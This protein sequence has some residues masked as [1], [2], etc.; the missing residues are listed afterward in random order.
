[1]EN[2]QDKI[3][4]NVKPEL[5]E[6]PPIVV[7]MGHV[8]HGK[9][10]LLDAIRKTNVVGKEAGGITQGIGAYEVTRINADYTQTDADKDA[11][12]RGENIGVDQR[13]NQRASARKITFIDTP[14]H[15]AFFAMR[16]HGAKLADVALLVVAADDGVRPQT[17]EAIKHIQEAKIPF[18]VVI[19]KTDKPG[20]VTDRV[21]KELADRDVLIEEWGGK[22]P[23]AAVSAKTGEGIDELLDLILLVAELEEL[24]YDPA[25]PGE[26]YVVEANLDGRR[27]VTATIIITSGCFKECDMLVCGSVFGPIKIMEDDRGQALEEACPSK[28]VRVV[29][30]SELPLV[31]EK[32]EIVPK[33]QD[34]SAIISE[35]EHEHRAFLE[36]L[37]IEPAGQ[38]KILLLV[39]KSSAQGSLAAVL[40]VLKEIKSDR[41]GLKLLKH[42][43]GD[44]NQSDV[45]QAETSAARVVGFRV[46]VNKEAA[47]YADQR[48]VVVKTFDV[49][50]EFVEA[51]KKMMAELLEPEIVK[52]ELGRLEILAVFKAGKPRAIV[53]G[54]IFSGKLRQGLKVEIFRNDVSLGLG[55]IVEL[56]RNK[57]P[58][59]EVGAGNEA[60]I[61]LES[62]AAAAV[63]DVLAGFEEERKYPEL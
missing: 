63:G 7:V 1:M 16:A 39:V 50:Y 56:Q 19:N 35:H 53:G 58:Q 23:L 22:V 33:G 21:K 3:L 6:R 8:D 40:G 20:A 47:S 18:I 44:I 24:K 25:S 51:V 4:V 10:T 9:T 36:S 42:E 43:V 48:G 11:D 49:I 29:G 60:G 55:K 37:K 13:D 26:G 14:G 62:D 31:G 32:C 34:V 59:A 12:L 30:L 46:G 38:A 41:V 15:E 54:K 45:K 61:L 52:T 5:K 27:G 57:E 17:E 28:P 2:L